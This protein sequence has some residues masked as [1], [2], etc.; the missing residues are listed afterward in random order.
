MFINILGYVDTM[1]KLL[2]TLP[3]S[4]MK[5]GLDKYSAKV[6]EPLNRQFPDRKSTEEA[7]QGYNARKKKTKTCL[8]PSG[9]LLC[10]TSPNLCCCFF[11][12]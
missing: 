3:K 8:F 11:D 12:E 4:E 1:K 5:K 9:K 7:V 10:S 2:F 6:P